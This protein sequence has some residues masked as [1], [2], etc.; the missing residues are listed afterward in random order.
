[1]IFPV[2]IEISQDVVYKHSVV[3]I[4]L[5]Y[6]QDIVVSNMSTQLGVFCKI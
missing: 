6:T 3:Y 1:M 4:A 5:G 2:Q